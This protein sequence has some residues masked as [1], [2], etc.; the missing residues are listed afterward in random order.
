MAYLD[1]SNVE[2]LVADIKALA[3]ATYFP[4]RLKGVNE[5]SDFGTSSFFF[6]TNVAVTLSPTSFILPQYAKG[7]YITT[8]NDAIIIAISSTG[9]E[10]V[11][12]RSGTDWTYYVN[13]NGAIVSEQSSRATADQEIKD[14][15][16]IIKNSVAVNSLSTI[17][18]TLCNLSGSITQNITAHLYGNALLIAGRVRISVTERTGSNGGIRY[19]IPSGK[20]IDGTVGS[21]YVGP[22]SYTDAPRNGDG[23]IISGADDSTYF[24]ILTSESYANIL[25]GKTLVLYVPPTIIKVK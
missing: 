1:S 17:S 12:Y 7:V 14:D 18:G 23:T 8:G 4:L 22:S 11:A 10:I 20:K 6:S 25:P 24:D 13:L 5:L 19:T 3:D 2:D 9:E 16:T 15:L 21:I